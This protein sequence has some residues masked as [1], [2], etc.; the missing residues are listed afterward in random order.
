MKYY[1]YKTSSNT[2]SK[3]I[4]NHPINELNKFKKYIETN[5]NFFFKNF[6]YFKKRYLTYKTEEYLINRFEFK[7]LLS[8]FILRRSRD[9]SGTNYVIL[10]HF[11]SKKI[12]PKHV[13]HLILNQNKLIF[14]SKKKIDILGHELL[15]LINFKIGYIKEVNLKEKKK[16][17]NNKEIF[18]GDT[19]IFI[20][21]E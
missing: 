12:K 6:D 2:L 1:L 10:D 19:D 18:L 17:L 11:G 3:K 16:F 4:K 14:L 13:N 8:F 20:N 21:L 5:N 15:D 9:K 7:K